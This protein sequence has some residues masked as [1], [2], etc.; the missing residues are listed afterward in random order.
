MVQRTSSAERT[1]QPNSVFHYR[2]KNRRH[3]PSRAGGLLNLQDT[4][5]RAVT[6]RNSDPVLPEKNRTCR[7][8]Y[9][10]NN[11]FSFQAA[12][13]TR[14]QRTGMA[15]ARFPLLSGFTFEALKFKYPA[16]VEPAL[17]GALLQ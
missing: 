6:V 2:P 11:N 13:N 15:V 12:V 7:Y 9:E 3:M 17:Y 10:G 16:F 1:L 14:T 5:P 4:L 8:Q